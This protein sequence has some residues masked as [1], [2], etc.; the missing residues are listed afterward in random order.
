MEF[1]HPRFLQKLDAYRERH[2]S[3]ALGTYVGPGGVYVLKLKDRGEVLLVKVGTHEE[4]RVSADDF[5][6]KFCWTVID[7]AAYLFAGEE[8]RV[9]YDADLAAQLRAMQFCIDADRALTVSSQPVVDR[10]PGQ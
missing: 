2:G 6:R 7:E 5:A 3:D 8:R 4:T 10:L 1:D 9:A